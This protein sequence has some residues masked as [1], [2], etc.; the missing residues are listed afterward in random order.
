MVVPQVETK[1]S[2]KPNLILCKLRLLR[3]STW[4]PTFLSPQLIVG[5]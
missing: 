1:T 2:Q 4:D 3:P 5:H